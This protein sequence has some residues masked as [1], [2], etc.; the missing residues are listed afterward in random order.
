[1]P[2]CTTADLIA[3]TL[4]EDELRQLTDDEGI[5]AVNSARVSAA[6]D[7]GD[8]IIDGYL[9]GRYILPLT[10]VPSLI[11]KLSVDLAV[12]HLYQRRRRDAMPDSLQLQYK[13]TIGLLDKIQKG[14]IVLGIDAEVSPAPNAGVTYF[15]N[16]TSSDRT[17]TKDVLDRY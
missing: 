11:R 13:N 9:R 15:T 6:I 2:Y 3:A 16:K 4:S 17:F 8:Q 7:A 12:Y 14:T 10:V 5:G 1:M